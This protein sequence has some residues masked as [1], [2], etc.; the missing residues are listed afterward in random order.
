MSWYVILRT[1]GTVEMR[2]TEAEDG[3]LTLRELQNAV[4]GHIE[5]CGTRVPETVMIV[6]EEGKLDGLGVNVKATKMLGGVFL[7]I[8][9]G[10]AAIVKEDGEELIGM[11]ESEI[12]EVLGVA[13]V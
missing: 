13:E 9:V 1:D 4:G 2:K 7:D 12:A 8:I 6:N 10:D 5:V 11:T 3:V